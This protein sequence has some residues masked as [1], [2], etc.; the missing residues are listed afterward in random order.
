MDAFNTKIFRVLKLEFSR[1]FDEMYERIKKKKK[2]LEFHK[3]IWLVILQSFFSLQLYTFKVTSSKTLKK[4]KQLLNIHC[5]RVFPNCS[6]I[7]GDQN[8]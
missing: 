6:L 8:F 4:K 3:F 5:N 2:Q 7:T 1:I